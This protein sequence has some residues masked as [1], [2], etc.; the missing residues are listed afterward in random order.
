MV[1]NPNLTISVSRFGQKRLMAGVERKGK[2]DTTSNP[3]KTHG[4]D[5]SIC[6]PHG[7][8]LPRWLPYKIDATT[9]KKHCKKPIILGEWSWKPKWTK[10][11][12]GR[13]VPNTIC[14]CV[15]FV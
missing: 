9:T 3:K 10:K 4:D 14:F 8:P 6:G 2:E 12:G 11:V 13:R 15:V 7:V 5:L 1:A